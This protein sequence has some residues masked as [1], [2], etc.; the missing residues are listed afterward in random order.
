MPE[1]KPFVDKTPLG[2]SATNDLHRQRI[3]VLGASGFIGRRVV[4]V[5]AAS[6]WARPIA[7]W[8]RSKPD[9]D[10]AVETRRFDA[11]QPA[12]MQAALQDVAGVV[13]CITGDKRSIV[14]SATALFD[15]GRQ[16]PTA[17]RIVH[18][19]TMMVYGT[20]TGVVDETAPLRGDWDEYSAAKGEVEQLALEYPVVVQLRPGIVYGPGSPIWSARI[21]R[22]LK[23]RRLGDLGSAGLGICN[24]VHIDD[25]VEAVCRSLR[26]PG[27]E[28]QV[29]NLSLTDPPTWN[30]YFRQF[31][32][33]LGTT[34]SSISQAR[35]LFEQYLLA[36]PLK[37][38]EYVARVLPFPPSPEPIRPWLMRLC[39]H[40]LRLDVRRAEEILSMRWIPLDKG[41]RQTAEWLTTRDAAEKSP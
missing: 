41:L 32:A 24:L 22:W 34:P 40:P 19:S 20:T 1:K 2:H 11:T 15:A 12:A 39:A 27:I 37:L 28:G 26:M 10:A 36:P 5:L 18:L 8:H 38:A 14:A 4:Q 30:D 35:L 25:V 33:A 13:N 7:A 9:S 31:A 6:D 16:R 29:F 21:G 3:L 23:Q 17:P